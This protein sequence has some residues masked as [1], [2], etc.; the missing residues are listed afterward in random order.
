MMFHRDWWTC[1]TFPEVFLRLFDSEGCRQYRLVEQRTR[2]SV[3][4]DVCSFDA[5]PSV[6]VHP[7]IHTAPNTGRAGA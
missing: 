1:K 3:A 6:C 2:S 7:Y 5:R 4:S